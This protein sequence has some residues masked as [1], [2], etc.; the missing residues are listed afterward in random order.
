[1]R[2]L[3]RSSMATTRLPSASR[4]SHRCEPMN[5]APPVTSAVRHAGAPAPASAPT[6]EVG[7][8]RRARAG[9]GPAQAI[10]APLS[11]HSVGRRDHQLEARLLRR[12]PPSARGGGCSPPRRRPARSVSHALRPRPPR[13][14]WRPGPRPPPPGTTPPRPAAGLLAAARARALTWRTTAV[15][16]PGEREVE[17]AAVGHRAG[18]P[19]RGRIAR[20]APSASSAGPPGKPRP[21]NRATLSKASPAASSSVWPEHLVAERLGHVHEHRVAAR[22]QEARRTAPRSARGRA[23]SRRCGPPGGSRR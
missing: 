16:K 21:R 22:D 1:M 10:M 18:E 19:D 13:R 12:A 3:D 14:S 7:A 11:V 20:R 15:F 4:R 17:V 6:A 9:G 8:Y 5:P 23:S 2:P